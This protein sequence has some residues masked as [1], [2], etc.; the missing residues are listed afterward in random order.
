MDTEERE[1]LNELKRVHIKRLRQLRLKEAQFGSNCPAEILI[2]ISEIE[3]KITRID[4][5]LLGLSAL[6]E[7][8]Q[9]IAVVTPQSI[10]QTSDNHQRIFI[11][12]TPEELISWF[13]GF[14]N[15]LEATIVAQKRFIGKYIRYVGVINHDM[16]F[17]TQD[18]IVFGLPLVV[19]SLTKDDEQIYK[20][21][22]GV[23]NTIV[24]CVYDIQP[25]YIAINDVSVE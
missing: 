12:E 4:N 22:R 8:P 20:I 24:G 1:Y 21:R 15:H 13:N 6:P 3:S 17:I 9:Q 19:F 18:S 11:K 23:P 7:Q 16:T 10:V 2:E 14:E 25:T 5:Q